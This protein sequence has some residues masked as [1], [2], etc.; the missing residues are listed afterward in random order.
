MIGLVGTAALAGFLVIVVF[1]YVA[2]QR[3][4]KRA[5]DG[6]YAA[7]LGI[8]IFRHDTSVMFA[9]EW[10]LIKA[11]LSHMKCGLR[12]LAVVIV[13]MIAIIAQLGLFYSYRPLLPGESS[14]VIITQAN[15]H[16]ELITDARLH[17]PSA[18]TVETPA[19]RIPGRG[20]VYWRI[21]AE[22]PGV[23]ELTVTIDDE[24]Y[25]KAVVVGPVD[26]IR[27]LSR[28]RTR[29]GF[30][31]ILFESSEPP[32]PV[33]AGIDS[34]QVRYP[35]AAWPLG[36]FRLHWLVPFLAITLIVGFTLKVYWG[37]QL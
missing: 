20:Q 3:S 14:V 10:R 30:L 1:R 28:I 27:R 13:P 16:W 26:N 29:R 31:A 2:D 21:K 35:P 36:P 25:Q 15:G 7:L 17:V 19:L 5:K 9:E 33:N 32:L 8:V 18:I 4:I 11:S 23:H 24:G 6:I 22:K 34:I 37:V 12:P